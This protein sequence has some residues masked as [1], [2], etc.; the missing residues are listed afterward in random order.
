MVRQW[1]A[2]SSSSNPPTPHPSRLFTDV[3]NGRCPKQ[4]FFWL[5]EWPRTDSWLVSA[6]DCSA[7]D[8]V[9]LYIFSEG[10]IEVGRISDICFV[11]LHHDG[12]E[13]G[14]RT[15]T[16]QSLAGNTL[17]DCHY[18]VM[19]IDVE[20]LFWANNCVQTLTRDLTNWYIPSVWHLYWWLPVTISSRIHIYIG[21]LPDVTSGRINQCWWQEAPLSIVSCGMEH[22]IWE[23]LEPTLTLDC[24]KG[25]WVTIW[26]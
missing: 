25:Y 3:H 9:Y 15:P 16:C 5:R 6:D 22:W 23:R 21:P 18:F 2:Q 4:K 17:V 1:N 12:R 7:S 8:I 24:N 10:W 20:Q 14:F 11:D 19:I 26:E 13:H